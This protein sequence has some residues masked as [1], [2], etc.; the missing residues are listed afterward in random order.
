[1]QDHRGAEQLDAASSASL[2]L[3]LGRR[4]HACFHQKEGFLWIK[5]TQGFRLSNPITYLHAIMFLLLL[6]GL[7]E[8]LFMRFAEFEEKV[9]EVERARWVPPACPRCPAPAAAAANPPI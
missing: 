9:K 3:L 1:M 4:P 5:R 6:P 2:W 8:E 7:Q